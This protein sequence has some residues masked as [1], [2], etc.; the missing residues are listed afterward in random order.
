MES[1]GA[2]RTWRHQPDRLAKEAR[3][4]TLP[5]RDSWRDAGLQ[6]P[7]L[8]DSEL[9]EIDPDD[10]GPRDAGNLLEEALSGAESRA[11][12]AEDYH[13]GTAR[14][15]LDGEANEADVAEQAEEVPGLDEEDAYAEE[16]AELEV[17]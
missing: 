13:P 16:P 10:L 3:M 5:G 15:D 8:R 9:K 4:S 17:P 12:A 11:A 1:A 6:E 7:G 2:S 14:P